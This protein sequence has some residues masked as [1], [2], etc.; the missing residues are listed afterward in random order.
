MRPIRKLLVANRGEIAVRII[1]ACRE[2]GIRAVA[3]FSDADREAMHVRLADEAY[4][5]GPAPAVESYLRADAIVDAA[6][7]CGADAIHPGYGFLSERSHFARAC[8]EAGLTFVGPSPEAIEL[9]GSKVAAKRL[10]VANDV[11][12]VPG[13]D[14]DDQDAERLASEAE[15]IGFPLLIKASAGGGGKGMRVVGQASEFGPALEGARREARAAFGDDTVLLEKLIVRPRHVEI[16]IIAD[17]HGNVVYLGE[18]ECSI[19]RRHQKIVEEAPCVALSESLRAAMGAAAVRLTRAA[20]YRNAGTVEFILDADGHPYFLEMNTRLQVEHPVTEYV[21]GRDLV[22]LQL[23]VASGAPLPFAQQDVS[24]RGHAIEVRVYAEDPVTFLPAVG[25]VAALAVPAGPGIR[26]DGG[27]EAG[28]EVSVHYDPIVAKLIVHAADRA[29]AVAR[30]RAAVDDFAV[31]GLTTNLGLLRAIAND[32]SFAA[33]ATHTGF[34]EE[35]ALVESIRAASVPPE[36]LVAATLHMA[37]EEQREADPFAGLWR[38]GGGSRRVR[39]LLEKTAVEVLYRRE[40]DRRF[41]VSAGDETLDVDVVARRGA[42]LHLRLGRR[43]E[44]FFVALVGDAV[45]VQWRGRH[46]HLRAAQGL[47]VDDVRLGESAPAGHASLEAPMSGTIVKVL[48]GEGDTV[49]KGAPLVVLEAMK[50]EHTVAAPHDGVVV[51]LP[52]R[53]GQLVS[54]GATLVELD[55]SSPAPTP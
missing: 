41:R 54:G 50:M 16:Q 53:V 8:A 11:P 2:Q 12:V 45:Y 10:A 47:R 32:P 3:V 20:G 7:G 33:G 36:V 40:S 22:H 49:A 1:R 9:L 14:G 21:T 52:Y 44:Q 4:P 51:K 13:Y 35:H 28:D 17:H 30:L 15:R 6:R 24:L 18:R 43:Q 25:P 34:L 55:A 23:A 37:G 5:I 38:D 39:L 26:V 31:L 29:A 27:L 48:V 46:Y 19:Q 42:G